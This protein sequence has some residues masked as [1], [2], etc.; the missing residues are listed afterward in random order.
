M[1]HNEAF[2][3]PF[4][5]WYPDHT[6]AALTPSLVNMPAHNALEYGEAVFKTE[7][8]QLE[9]MKSPHFFHNF[10]INFSDFP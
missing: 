3:V 6:F 2:Q 8:K 4:Y 10:S 7:I 5:W 9:L 1:T